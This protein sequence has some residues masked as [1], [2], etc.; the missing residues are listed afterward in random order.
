LKILLDMKLDLEIE[1]HERRWERSLA[2]GEVVG[3]GLQA[4][5]FT[6]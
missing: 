3:P 1:E 6:T 5:T 2:D 4:A